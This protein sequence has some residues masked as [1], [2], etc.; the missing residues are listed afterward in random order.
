[1]MSPVSAARSGDHAA[2]SGVVLGC[3]ARTRL[4]LQNGIA[5]HFKGLSYLRLRRLSTLHNLTTAVLWLHEV[6][7]AF[8]INRFNGLVE[9][10]LEAF[11]EDQLRHFRIR[12][13]FDVL[14]ERGFLF[15]VVIHGF[16]CLV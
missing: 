13:G 11:S 8:L 1:M 5:N 7:N 2:E 6:R 14:G 12:A 3:R 15:G 9:F 4:P 10:F 16:D